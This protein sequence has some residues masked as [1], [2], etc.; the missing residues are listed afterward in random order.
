MS[1][2]RL[3]RQAG[4][5]ITVMNEEKTIEKFLLSLL[6][7]YHDLNEIVIVDGGSTD[8]T[9]EIII[10]FQK[11]HQK[12]PIRLL[13]KKGNIATG[14]NEAIKRSSSDIILCSDAGCI[15]DKNWVS[16]MIH[17]F[18]QNIDVVAGY[19][20]PVTDSTF[21]KCL[22]TYT[23]VMPDKINEKNYLPSSRSVG[24]RKEAWEEVGGYPNWLNYCE[25]LYFARELKRSKFNF[26][27]AKN[28]VVYWPQRKNIVQAFRQFFNYAVGDGEAR[29]VRSNTPFLFARYV[30][31]LILILI[32]LNT[33][34]NN[35]F[36][37]IILSLFIYVIW[38]IQKNYKYV[39]KLSAFFYL[40]VL[41][42]TSDFAVILGMSIGFIKSFSLKK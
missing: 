17:K 31:G 41:Q 32:F 2:K 42:F 12:M 36:Y 29:Y 25:D 19:Y 1:K 26:N 4:L 27:F 34:N 16:E 18:K 9:R 28:A 30:I 37:F 35:L 11:K 14:R 33:Q 21:E 6:P 40:P 10:K 24:F 22:A 23:C 15:L 38:S 20:K 39:K 3:K 13:S 8:K 5:I 7:Q